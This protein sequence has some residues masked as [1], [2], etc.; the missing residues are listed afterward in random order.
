MAN[1]FTAI[2]KYITQA[3]DTVFAE[4]SK[5]ALLE[6][7]QKFIN[8]NFDEAGY[9]KVLSILMDGLSDYYRV[10]GGTV[11]NSYAHH[12][13][14]QG[15]G[16]HKGNVDTSWEIFKLRYD[17]GKQFQIDARDDEE[18][19]S[20]IIGNLLT[21][22]LRTHVVPEVDAMRFS[23][24]AGK[25]YESLG[26]LANATPTATKGNTGIIH[27]LNVGFEWLS[28]HEV[29]SEDQIIFVS[30]SVM[31]LLK[32]T[33]ELTHFISQEDMRSDRG[34]NFTI[35][36]YDGRPV[37]AVPDS[38]FYTDAQVYPQGGFGPKVGDSA[39]IN[40]MIV[41]KKCAIPIVKI[42]KTQ[43]FAPN[44]VQ[45]FDGYKVNFRMYHDLIIPKNKIIGAY[46]CYDSS[47]L[48]QANY[49]SSLS[50]ALSAGA[51]KGTSV[52]DGV[53]TTP[54]GMLGTLYSSASAF[55]LQSAPAST[56]VVVPQD[57]TEFTPTGN[58]LYF[59]LVSNGV[60]VATTA[61]AV[62]VPVS[63]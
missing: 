32:E 14:A 16:Y 48:A 31:T 47:K 39:K 57:G 54:A 24:I 20:L 35:P 53:Y 21:E 19:A 7:G 17:R 37:I 27:L 8:V 28:Q 51:T 1:N 62:S 58:S 30:P 42:E 38:R 61:S 18:S 60:V 26:N 46:T 4:E 10:N 29:P 52:V 50:V 40:F 25:C 41:S 45:D 55:A 2:T 11:A 33:N 5:T 59:A 23:A 49:A 6:N 44:V 43:V 56:A 12:Q 63:E 22:F 13:D 9:V 36:A 3:V 34:I 15:D